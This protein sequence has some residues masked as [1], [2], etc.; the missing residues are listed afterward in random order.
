L[1][2]AKLDQGPAEESGAQVATGLAVG[3]LS[4]GKYDTNLSACCPDCRGPAHYRYNE[5]RPPYP[6][7]MAAETTT[8]IWGGGPQDLASTA[9]QQR[10]F[11]AVKHSSKS[12]QSTESC[13]KN[14]HSKLAAAK[15]PCR[16]V[17]CD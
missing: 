17:S 11:H 1:P 4:C 12:S 8:E 6:T 13:P 16:S 3:N 9:C 14:A 2:S 7:P 10:L 5:T 15:L